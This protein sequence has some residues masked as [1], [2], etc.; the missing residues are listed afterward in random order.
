MRILDELQTF[1]ETWEDGLTDGYVY[2]E[3]WVDKKRITEL[4][5]CVLLCPDLLHEYDTTLKLFIH[6]ILSEDHPVATEW[7]PIRGATNTE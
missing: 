2:V 4:K 6:E 5:D 3:G 1:W 7:I